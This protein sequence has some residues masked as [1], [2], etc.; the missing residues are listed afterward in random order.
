MTTT[1][2]HVVI[3]GAGAA[4]HSAASTLR[5]EGYAD[6]IT[7]VHG[8]Q[9]APYNRTLVNKGLLPGILTA[10]QI[11]LPGLDDLGVDLV[12]ARVRQVAHE[13]SEKFEVVLEDGR[14]LAGTALVAATGSTPRRLDLAALGPEGPQRVL[15]LHT[16]QDAARARQLLGD[17]PSRTR[18]TLLGAGF[19]G[20]ETASHLAD[21]GAVVHLVSQPALPMAPALGHEVARR[22][23]DLHQ[24]HVHA[25]FGRT[26][27]DLSVDSDTV[28]VTLDDGTQ[29]ESD[30]ALVAYGTVPSSRWLNGHTI[31]I[32]VDDRLRAS[33]LPRTY[34]AGSVAIHTAS[35]G[36]HYRLDHWD[37]ATAQGAHAARVLLHDLADAPDPGPYLPTTGFT[38]ILYRQPIA[39]Y[40]VPVP[41]ATQ[42]QHHTATGSGILTT[43]HAASTQTLT[44]AAGLGAG[45]ELTDLRDQLQR[46]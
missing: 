42:H 31:G 46:P 39:G 11:A 25:H 18:V 44:A 20:A 21:L 4:G 29:L 19:I 15:H 23:A 13:S 12:R 3:A 8:E 26:L 16:V 24:A 14:R 9:M 35:D 36:T 30:I 7:L 10:E 43:F 17:D 37:A 40:G 22:V 34:A 41:G 1:Q 32:E 28:T 6:A 27:V 2:Q 38:T 45:R 33:D 5:R